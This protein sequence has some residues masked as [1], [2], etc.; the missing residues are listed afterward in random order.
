MKKLPIFWH[1]I[2]G[3]HMI[4]IVAATM[5]LYEK[6]KTYQATIINKDATIAREREK[7]ALLSKQVEDQAKQIRELTINNHKKAKN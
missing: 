4:V 6:S 5:T 1:L 2:L 3:A 7:S